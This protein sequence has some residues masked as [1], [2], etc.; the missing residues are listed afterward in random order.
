MDRDT[1]LKTLAGLRLAI[2]VTSWVAPNFGAKLFGLAPEA[3]AQGP[4]LGR[5]FGVRDVALAL[6]PLRSKRK[7]QQ[8]WLEMGML[9]DAAD[10]AAALI[11]G[12]KGYL[13]PS[14]TA[15]VTAPAVA[16]LALGAVALRG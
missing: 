11:G 4:Y 16:A 14:T 1:A 2:G 5:L 13:S 9:C 10:A 12:G 6:G 15:M 3:N 8:N 7:A